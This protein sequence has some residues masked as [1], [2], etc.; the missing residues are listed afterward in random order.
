MPSSVRRSIRMT[1]HSAMVAI[2]ATT[3]RFSLRTIGRAVIVLTVRRACDIVCAS[4]TLPY[5]SMAHFAPGRAVVNSLMGKV[6]RGGCDAS[7][8]R[9][10]A[11]TDPG[12]GLSAVPPARLQPGHDGRYCD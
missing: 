4:N 8:G 2:L 3:G 1:G 12:R 9:K 7:R 6:S 10:D 5:G 11:A